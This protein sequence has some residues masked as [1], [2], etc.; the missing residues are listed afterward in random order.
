M[1][2]NFTSN[3]FGVQVARHRTE[4]KKIEG[5]LR[6]SPTG[7]IWL[8][9]FDTNTTPPATGTVPL[10]QW[11]VYGTSEFFKE[12]ERGEITCYLGCY[13]ALS[14]TEGTF[15]QDL[16]DAMD[17]SVEVCSPE[18]PIV[19]TFV[20][21]LTTAATGLTVWSEATGAT[22][23]KTL[24][25]LEVDGTN[26]TGGTQW[27]MLFAT[28]TVNTGDTPI[29]GGS[30]PINPGQKRTANDKLTFGEF[31][32]VIFSIDGEPNDQGQGGGAVPGTKRLGC[33]V[34]I[35]STPGTYTPANGTACIKAEY[36][37]AEE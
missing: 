7:P 5:Y 14:S 15:T 8:Q 6:S 33:T 35:S 30:F 4:V 20:G 23:R 29:Q 13:I 21:D 9:V 32:R 25:A 17:I 36:K 37:G 12:F 19:I 22:A 1:I 26:L 27:I 2:P 18:L 31:G 24:I 28:D 16:T 3:T 34:K 11:P 10:K